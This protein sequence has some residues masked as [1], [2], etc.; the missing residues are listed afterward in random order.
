[1]YIGGYQT[2]ETAWYPGASC[3]APKTAFSFN[4][5]NTNGYYYYTSIN[6][7]TVYPINVSSISFNTNNSCYR[8]AG[9]SIRCIQE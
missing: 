8:R 6:Q 2:G 3:R 7:S 4:P 5:R 9:S 1:M